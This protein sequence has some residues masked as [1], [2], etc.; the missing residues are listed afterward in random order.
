[1]LEHPVHYAS[2]PSLLPRK[3]CV[4]C[5]LCECYRRVCCNRALDTV[6]LI[7][8]LL[9]YVV[10]PGFPTFPRIRH[11]LTSVKG[12]DDDD[13]RCSRF[14]E[15]PVDRAVRARVS[16]ARRHVRPSTC[17]ILTAHARRESRRR[18]LYRFIAMS[19]RRISGT[20]RRKRIR[21]LSARYRD[22][23]IPFI[24]WSTAITVYRNPVIVP[25]VS[26]RS[27]ITPYRFVLHARWW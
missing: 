12:F 6:W 14:G 1:M 25:F 8:L 9:S 2:V 18:M 27:E 7:K 13:F 10:R 24:T 19:R 22:R 20:L 16:C 26:T 21:C 23:T 5:V 15:F 11:G 4:L 3:K 17:V